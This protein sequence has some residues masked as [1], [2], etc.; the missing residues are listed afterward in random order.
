[1]SEGYGTLGHSYG[2]FVALQHMADGPG[3]AVAT[4]VSSGV[5]S[6]RFLDGVEQE[7]ARFEPEA[8]RTQV[9][10]SWAREAA[11][12]T[13]QDCAALMHD[14]LPFHF[15]DPLD[16][17]IAE[18]EQRTAGTRYAP[19][20]LRHASLESGGL[21]IEVEHR[22]PHVPQPVLVTTGRKDRTCR[23]DAAERI[24]E[25]VPHAELH[26]FEASGHMTFVEQNEEYVAVVR[27]FLDRVTG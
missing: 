20:V 17:R 5:P 9:T 21:V 4:V 25:L 1:M 23:V 3:A 22:L 7:L 10:D 12:T 14:Q 19:D 11:V 27:A 18:Y 8:L 6:G 15:G 26:I 2:A 16:P 24:A 13:E